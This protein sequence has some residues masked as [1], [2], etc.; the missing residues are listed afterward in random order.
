MA[1]I[2]IVHIPCLYQLARIK[3]GPWMM[4]N[5]KAVTANF[6]VAG[7]TVVNFKD[8]NFLKEFFPI[9]HNFTRPSNI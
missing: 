2:V 4:K 8:G 6:T 1:H 5:L 7:L 3:T 9:P